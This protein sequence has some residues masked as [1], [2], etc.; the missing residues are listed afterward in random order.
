MAE[1]LHVDGLS[2]LKKALQQLPKNIAKNVLRGAVNAGAVV[3]RDEAKL[4]APVMPEAAPDHQPPGT[5]R[6]AII[7]KQIPEKSGATQQTYYVTVRQGKRYRGQGAKGNK[8]QDAFYAKWVEFGHYY[9]PPKPKGASWKKHRDMTKGNAGAKWVPPK[10][11][12][13]PAFEAKKRD[14]VA[15][16]KAYLE[17]RIPQEVEKA[18]RGS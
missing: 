10:P 15:A 1:L 7:V 3:I 17:K 11:F 12:L 13:R 6:R 14:A 5:L 9:V 8:S 18:R 16:I 2:E 4:R